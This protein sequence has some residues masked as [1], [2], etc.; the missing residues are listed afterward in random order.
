V[1]FNTIFPAHGMLVKSCGLNF[2]IF[3]TVKT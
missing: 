3:T 2:Y 1:Q